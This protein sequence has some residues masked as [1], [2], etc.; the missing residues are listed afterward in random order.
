MKKN[1]EPPKLKIDM[2]LVQK[3]IQLRKL[4]NI[5]MEFVPNES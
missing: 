1:L 4:K 2:S 3:I 5:A